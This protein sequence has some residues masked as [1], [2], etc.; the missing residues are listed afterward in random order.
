MERIGEPDDIGP[1]VAFLASDA[2]RWITGEVI[3]VDGGQLLVSQA[4][5]AR[6]ASERT[7]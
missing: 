5:E 3:T 4:A 7:A 6:G 1:V 2:S